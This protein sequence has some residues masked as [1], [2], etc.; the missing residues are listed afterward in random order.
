MAITKGDNAYEAPTSLPSAN[1]PAPPGFAAR[2]QE[3][4]AGPT[5]D[6][7]TAAPHS[8][9][10]AMSVPPSRQQPTAAGRSG[11]WAAGNRQAPKDEDKS[12]L[13]NRRPHTLTTSERGFGRAHQQERTRVKKLVD[14]GAAKCSRCGHRIAPGQAWHLDHA[15]TTDAHRRGLYRGPSHA[16]CNLAARNRRQAALARQAQGLPPVEDYE[17]PPRTAR[18]LDW[19][20]PRKRTP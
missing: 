10:D 11:S 20:N 5:V 2:P 3:W 8:A 13:S 4:Q 6:R 12:S 9:F 16:H 17:E 1:P 14:A 7:H 15:D 18:A 19:F